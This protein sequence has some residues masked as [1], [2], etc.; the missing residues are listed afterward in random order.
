[1]SASPHG[2]DGHD[3]EIGDRD[4]LAADPPKPSADGRSGDDG[5]P[6][7]GRWLADALSAKARLIS[8]LLA[9]SLSW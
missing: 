5:R 9:G 3:V 8:G 6:L 1:M 2:T 7:R 4:P